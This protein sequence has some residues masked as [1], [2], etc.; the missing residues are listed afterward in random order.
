MIVSQ[1]GFPEATIKV[2][3]DS[4]KPGEEL[5]TL[6]NLKAGIS[7]LAAGAKPGDQL[8]M[9]YSGHGGQV[10]DTNGDETDGYDGTQ[11]HRGSLTHLRRRGSHPLRLLHCGLPRRRLVRCSLEA[12]PA[13]PG[14]IIADSALQVGGESLP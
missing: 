7:W 11:P 13:P 4:G 5:P 9:H 14:S 1:F 6:A 3:R 10:V 12:P 8:V 2:L